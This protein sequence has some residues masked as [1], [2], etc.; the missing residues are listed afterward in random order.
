MLKSVKIERKKQN[1]CACV[2][3]AFRD[4]QKPDLRSDDWG[5]K[6]RPPVGETQI[7]LGLC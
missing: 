2:S 5:E 6:L 4:T 1:M 7:F 3:V